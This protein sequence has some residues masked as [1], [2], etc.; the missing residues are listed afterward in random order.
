MKVGMKRVQNIHFIILMALSVFACDSR[1]KWNDNYESANNPEKLHATIQKL[2]GVMMQETVSS[3]VAARVYAYASIAAYE[4][5]AHENSEYLSLAGQ[6]HDLDAVPSLD[7]EKEYFMPLASLQ[8]FTSVVQGIIFS[9]SMDEYQ[10]E[11]HAH[12]GELSIPPV[13]FE[14]SIEFGNQMSEY[15]LS[16][17]ATDNYLETRNYPQYIVRNDVDSW[18]PTAPDYLE[19][20][21]PHWSKIRPFVMDSSGQFIPEP[22]TRFDLSPGS[23]FFKEVLE[24]YDLTNNL[25]LK[26][27]EIAE[28]WD[29]NP[30]VYKEQENVPSTKKITSGGRW[31]RIAGIA[32]KTSSANFIESTEAYAR[33]AISINDGII[34]CWSE[35]WRSIVIRPETIIHA[36]VDENWSS[37]LQS[38][39]S[40]EYT[41]AHSV[42]A[43][44]ASVALTS[45]F[46]D[47]FPFAED[48]QSESGVSTRR[49]NS[50]YDASAEAAISRMYGGIHYI[51]SIN[52]GLSQGKQVGTF[53]DE[54]LIT[55]K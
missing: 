51:P 35:K 25:N 4:V 11:L 44:A 6:L 18:K 19:G 49:F 31:M 34:S 48:V 55:R 30:S 36:Y 2:T 9:A 32:C 26:Q 24:V 47:P 3:P 7:P 41:S 52:N 46:G 16:W 27:K 54:S 17:S 37:L 40:P 53:I 5:M 50:F 13:V 14:N 28:F 20:M 29:D 33:T 12:F 21:E 15:I 22:P 10:G 38:P 1:E 23:K 8:A 43:G 45:L 39:P 42:V